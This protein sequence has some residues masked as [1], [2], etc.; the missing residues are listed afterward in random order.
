MPAMPPK[1]WSVDHVLGQVGIYDLA[2]TYVNEVGQNWTGHVTEN[3][4]VICTSITGG[5]R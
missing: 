2:C 3:G 1:A 4:I 5:L